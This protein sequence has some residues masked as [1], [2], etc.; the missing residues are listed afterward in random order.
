LQV[1]VDNPAGTVADLRLR[2]TIYA[3][4]PDGRRADKPA[5]TS[6]P[7]S[8]QVPAGASAAAV[9]TATIPNRALWTLQKPSLYVGVVAVEQA[10]KVVDTYETTFGIR[11]I[12]FE[13]EKGFM[14]N[15]EQIKFQGVCDH[16][17]LGALGAA[18]NLRALERQ[19]E[20]L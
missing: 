14:L 5:A 7:V 17:D 19:L 4:T 12:Q 6:S 20:L 3:L 13:P 18:I 2:A 11:T 15:G 16:H 8:L 9:I 10:G 1:T